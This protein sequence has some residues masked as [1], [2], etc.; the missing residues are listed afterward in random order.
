MM[1]AQEELAKLRPELRYLRVKVETIKRAHLAQKKKADQLEELLKVRDQIIKELEQEN[2]SLGKL[3][4][5]LKSQR[6]TYRGMI[7]KENVSHDKPEI[8][9]DPSNTKKSIGGQTGHIGASR[10]VPERVDFRKRVFFHHCPDCGSPLKRTASVDTHTVEDI[11]FLVEIKTEVT[12]YECERQWC[13]NCAKEVVAYPLEVIPNSRLGIYLIIQILIF[14]YACRMPLGV[15]VD[16]LCQSYGVNLTTAGVVEVLKRAKVWFGDEY[17]S[18]LKIIRGS[19]V[20]HA[21]ETG[22]RING[23]NCWLWAFLTKESIYYTIEKTRGGGVAER[24]LGDSKED[25]VLVRDDYSGYKKLKLNQQA[26]WAHLLRIT[27]EFAEKD[28]ASEEVKLLYQELCGM[29]ANLVIIT[30]LPFNLQERSSFHQACQF[31]LDQIRDQS[32]RSDDAKAVQTRI[33]NQ[34]RNDHNNYLTALLFLDVDLTNNLAE[35]GIRKGVV[36]RKISG[37]SR[38]NL[39]AETF[40]VNMSIIQ[41]IK[42]RNQPLI[43]TLHS[44]ILKAA[45]GKSD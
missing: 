13:G 34:Q 2:T 8:S 25:D 20:K 3:I 5:D 17:G 41:T 10:K 12:R 45:L 15:L 33:R 16:T 42:L 35:R 24:A 21:D 23:L 1:T 37:G 19:P 26:C 40:A 36:T 30:K 38:S 27:R 4:E 18:L 22:W 7:Y 11:P 14:K 6:D 32:F 39:G 31:A 43:P 28:T 9:K 29:F 44:L